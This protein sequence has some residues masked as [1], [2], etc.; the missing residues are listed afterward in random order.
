MALMDLLVIGEGASARGLA[1]RLAAAAVATRL[2][3]PTLPLAALADLAGT[4]DAGLL[5]CADLAGTALP[6]LHGLREAGL[7]LPLLVL[8]AA[9]AADAAC[10]AFNLGADAV[11]PETAP[12]ATLLARIAAIRRRTP[13]RRASVLAC[14]N[15]ALDRVAGTLAVAGVPVEV[16]RCELDLLGLLIAARGSVLDKDRLLAALRSDESE[17]GS[18]V[19]RVFIC[20]LRRKLA[21]HGADDIIRTVW[22]VGYRVEAPAGDRPAPGTRL[23]G[24]GA[25]RRVIS[26]G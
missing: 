10:E 1:A 14:G 16:T 18:G 12:T 7:G 13:R 23:A 9:T 6:L 2:V 20:R 4:V 5:A 22:G 11:L 19:L 3:P 26:P 8:H 15:V 24:T 25:G 21:E 17:G